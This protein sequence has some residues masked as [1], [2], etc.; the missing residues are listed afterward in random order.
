MRR[1]R[2]QSRGHTRNLGPLARGRKPCSVRSSPDTVHLAPRFGTT[3]TPNGMPGGWLRG[4]RAPSSPPPPRTACAGAAD[5]RMSELDRPLCTLDFGRC[6]SV[7]EGPL[8]VP[9][10][11][12]RAEPCTE[13]AVRPVF[14]AGT[15]VPRQTDSTNVRLI[16]RHWIRPVASKP[17]ARVGVAG[18]TLDSKPLYV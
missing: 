16:Q 5:R 13:C 12:T 15:H 2:R 14:R 3:V 8:Y 6:S 7:A 11:H 9:F 17:A 1:L 4:S 10:R 18:A